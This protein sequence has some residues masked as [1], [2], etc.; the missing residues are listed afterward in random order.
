MSDRQAPR[1][2]SRMIGVVVTSAVVVALGLALVWFLPPAQT[3]D[4]PMP[5]SDAGPEQ[6]VRSYVDALD[7]HDCDRAASLTSRGWAE[8]AREW[9]RDLRS[10]SDLRIGDAAPEDPETAGLPT[11]W[12]VLHLPVTLRLT[13]RLGRGD[14]TR[15]TGDEPSMWGYRLARPNADSPWRIVGEGHA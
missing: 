10:I 4:V 12:E 1:G 7:A 3:R 15:D 9:C 8:H 13:H 11:S 2:G 5:R 14:R 6:V